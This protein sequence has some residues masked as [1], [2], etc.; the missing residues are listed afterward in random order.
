M[1]ILIFYPEN[2]LGMSDFR[3]TDYSTLAQRAKTEL[4]GKIPNFGNK[5]WLQGIISEI[6][7]SENSFEFGYEDLSYDYI[8]ANFDCVLLP[9]ANCFHKGWIPYLEK[10]ASI[11]QNI[12]IPVYVIACGIQ[13]NSYDEL[14]ELISSVK[15]P[16]DKFIR[17]VYNTGGE[18]A[19]RG[20]FTKEFFDRLGY[21][22]AVVTG[23][24]SLF[25]MGR[26]LKIPNEKVS[27]ENFKAT[28]NGTFKL[29]VSDKDLKNADYICQ[30]VY[31]KFLYDPQ[32]I[33]ETPFTQKRVLKYVKRGDFDFV[34]ALAN[35]KIKLFGDTQQW[36]SY[37]L[38]NNISFSFGSRI[39]GS[40][41]PILSGVPSLCYTK[42]ARTREM[43]EFFDIPSLMP[44]KN[45]Q[46]QDLYEL[47]CETDY[48]KFNNGFAKRY[49][50]FESFLISCGLVKKI[51]E[52]N[53]FMSKDII[54]INMPQVVNTN[55][56]ME[57]KKLIDKNRII[58]NCLD[59][60][61]RK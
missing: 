8:N 33:T 41:M 16:A 36:M 9:L 19:L 14:D 29:P 58:I 17:S 53:S 31:G 44:Q 25:Q 22:S 37:F 34:R 20:Y 40:I 18:F 59:K 38:I 42:D 32:F 50:A 35:N 23:C 46:K 45:E 21:K 30:D 7:S 27:R 12:K 55:E 57:L 3:P 52:N 49:D 54:D 1:K 28:I 10:R 2:K 39:H 61:Y 5:V 6:S 56:I 13:A 48:S 43:V 24:P 60:I 15:E 4:N 47:Y 26:N 51:N 11:L